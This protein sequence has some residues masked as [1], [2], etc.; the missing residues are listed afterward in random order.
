MARALREAGGCCPGQIGRHHRLIDLPQSPL[1]AGHEGRRPFPAARGGEQ[2]R[3]GQR[4]GQRSR[5]PRHRARAVAVAI[6]T[7]RRIPR[8]ASNAQRGHQLFLDGELDGAT[9]GL[10]DQFAECAGPTV[11]RPRRL[12]DILVHGVCLRWPP[13]QAAGLGFPNSPEACAILLFHHNRDTTSV[14][15]PWGPA[16][17]ASGRNRSLLQGCH[18]SY[19]VSVGPFLSSPTP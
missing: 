18:S 19:T 7:T 6:A 5:R 8:V 11:R 2:R 9:H 17:N 15:S 4:E 1:I 14:S 13:W 16:D 10:V 3:T 12:P